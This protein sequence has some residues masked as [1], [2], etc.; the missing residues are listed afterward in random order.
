MHFLWCR[1]YWGCFL[2]LMFLTSTKNGMIYN[3]STSS[4]NVPN[5]VIMTASKRIHNSM[6]SFINTFSTPMNE[7]IFESQWHDI[8]GWSYYQTCSDD[9][10]NLTKY[11]KKG[12][13][14][15]DFDRGWFL[16]WSALLGLSPPQSHYGWSTVSEGQLLVEKTF[17]KLCRHF[18]I[19]TVSHASIYSKDSEVVHIVRINVRTGAG[20]LKIILW[21][22]LGQE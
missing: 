11:T 15:K 8:S 3:G 10:S 13:F 4:S 2:F 6:W 21:L 14:Q 17:K 5:Y 16:K 19:Q 12:C 20:T 9:S 22:N 1:G 18:L 7:L